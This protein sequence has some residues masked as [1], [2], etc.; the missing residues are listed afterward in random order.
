[1]YKLSD[2]KIGDIAIIKSINLDDSSKRRLYDIGLVENTKLKV[3]LI[4]KNSKAYLIRNSLIAI[5]NND[6]KDILVGEI[7]D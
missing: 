2:L 5:R 1:M 3:M 4:K 7:N 6:S